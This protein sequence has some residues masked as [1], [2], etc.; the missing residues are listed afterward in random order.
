MARLEANLT[1]K[2]GQGVDYLC[3]MSDQYTEIITSKQKIDNADGFNVLATFGQSTTGIASAAGLRMKGAKLVVVKNNSPIGVELQFKVRDFKDD[4]NI[5]QTN[6][7][8]LGP[9]SAT[10]IRQFSYLLGANEYMVLPNQYMLSYAEDA[11]AANAKTI[12]NKGGYDV[13]SGRLYGDSGA[14][15]GAKLENS[16][17]QVTVD[18]TDYFRVGDLIQLGTTTGTTATNIEIM[19]VKS[20]DSAT[21][22]Q[23][24]RGLFGSITA[25][26][27]AQTSSSNGAV[28]GA[29]V[30]TPWFNT[31]ED[32]DKYHDNANAEGIVQTNKSGKYTS[33]NLFGYGRS[34]TY[35]TGIV[36]GSLALKLY[37]NGY[38]EFALSGITPSTHSGLAASTAYAFNITV[39]GGSEFASL[40]FTTDATNLNFGGNNGVISKIQ[41]ALNTQYYTSGNLF[42]KTVSVGIVNGDIRFTSGNRTRNSAISLAAPTS[43]TTPFGVGR[44][45][46]IGS[47]EAAVG[48]RLPDDT[49]FNKADYV[50]SKNQSAFAY[51]DGKGNINGV[52]TGTINYETGAL[53]LSGPVNT[54]FVASFNYDSAHSGGINAETDEQNTLTELGA[55]SLNSKIDAEVEIIGFV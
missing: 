35:P 52:L 45:P 15:L 39:D 4:S 50:Q 31:Q 42:E 30:Y 24:E 6:S 12:D 55:R 9:G 5:D 13:N 28:S 32:Y 43:G 22:M 1:V 7:V 41:A 14:N 3:D 18:D 10:T 19:R 51:D 36:K 33:Q 37:S 46:A 47:I 20:V 48:A 53:D 16:E 40:S 25:D 11:S 23:V 49:V 21:V 38:Q 17:T 29:N 54:E 44:L 2:T 8:D 34:A 27:D 26:G